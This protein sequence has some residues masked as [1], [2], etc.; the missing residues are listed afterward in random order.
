M[1]EDYELNIEYWH[2]EYQGNK[3]LHEFLG[4]SWLEYKFMV[5]V[6]GEH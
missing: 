5:E 6:S 2:T 1:L 4:L 3:P